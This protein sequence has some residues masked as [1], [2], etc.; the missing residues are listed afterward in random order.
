MAI[1]SETDISDHID[2]IRSDIATLSETVAQL[3][4]DTA[5]IQATLRK[6]LTTAVGRTA[7]AGSD[8]LSEAA[9]IGEDAVAAAARGATATARSIGGEIARNPLAAI[10]VALG[11]GFAVGLFTRK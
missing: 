1:K 7:S 2:R 3:V 6:R 10:L 9:A 4:S 11:F 5:G 8:L